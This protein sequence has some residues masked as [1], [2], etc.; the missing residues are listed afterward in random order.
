MLFTF[1]VSTLACIA[2]AINCNVF[3]LQGNADDAYTAHDYS[4]KEIYRSPQSPGYTCWVGA[5]AMPDESLMVSFTQATGPVDGR[6]RMPAWVQKKWGWPIAGNQAYDF[7]G[8]DLNNIYLRSDD[9]GVTWK[10]AGADPFK[11]PAGQMS[12]GGPQ[13]A[14]RD[15]TILRAVFGYHLPLDSEIPKTGFLQQSVDGAKSWGA[16][17]VLLDP[18]KFT[19]RIT[20]L[21]WLRD[22]R[23]IALGGIAPVASSS[24]IELELTDLWRPLLMVSADQGKT[25]SGPIEIVPEDG[26]AKW[27]GEEWDVA[28]L[29]NGDLL[30]VF[31]RIDPDDRTRQ[32]RWQGLLKKSGDG[33]VVER[34]Q[35]SVLPHSGHPELLATQEGPVLHIATTGI[36]CTKDAGQTWR[37]LEFNGLKEPYRTRYYPHSLQTSDG[38]IYVFAHFGAHDPYGKDQHIV[39]D[40]F[41]IWPHDE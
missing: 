38:T 20:R 19:Y 5:W 32:A 29:A 31:R 28:E 40:K 21:R 4:R 27:S 13:I 17:Q 12:Q 24:I 3:V 10:Q 15:G 7:T 41:R 22:G 34:L 11:T 37:E 8:L 6:P 18:D 35:R 16:P 36:H 9:A 2:C 39:M 30:A 25:W 23:M 33:W 26:P 1:R 14:L